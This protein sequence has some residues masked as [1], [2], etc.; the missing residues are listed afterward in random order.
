MTAIGDT[1]KRECLMRRQAK[2]YASLIKHLT[3]LRLIVNNTSGS[4][5]RCECTQAHGE[6]PTAAG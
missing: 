4:R 5:K 3:V 6:K 1:L 2:S